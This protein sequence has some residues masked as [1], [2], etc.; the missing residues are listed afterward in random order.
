[1]TTPIAH[2][3]LIETLIE[4]LRESYPFPDRAAHAA[5]RLRTGLADGSYDMPLGPDLCERISA[6]LLA[7][8]DDKHLRLLWHESIEE[9]QDEAT[10]VAGMAELF[11][12]ENHGLRRV[13]RLPENLGLIELTVIPPAASAGPAIAAAM[14]LVEH[15]QGLILDARAARGGSP[16]GVAFLCS[17]L[18]PDGD[19]HLGDIVEGPAGPA[20]QYWTSAHVPAPRYLDRPVYVLTSASTFSGGE[21]LAYNLQALRRATVVGEVTRGG[22]HPSEVVSLSEHVEL[23]LPV[24]RAVNPITGGNW[25]GVGVQPDMLT[26]AADALDVARRAARERIAA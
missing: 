4:R 25:E 8:C 23:R 26:T 22:A 18:F 14:R 16:D 24:A 11:R 7:A 13:E 21:E 5:S 15:T 2:S 1:M 17:F 12:L 10:L 19:V 6:D 20:R 3:A 9:S